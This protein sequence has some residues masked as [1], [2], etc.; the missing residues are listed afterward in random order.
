MANEIYHRSNWG[1]AVNDI[2]WGDVY[3]KFDATNEMFVRSDYYENS[4]ETDK[5]MADIYPKPSILLTPTAYDNGSLHS[6]KPVSFTS[7]EPTFYNQNG[8]SWDGSILLGSPATGNTS[9]VNDI[10]LDKK[11]FI[12]TFKVLTYV[13]GDLGYRFGGGAVN[14]NYFNSELIEGNTIKLE[15]QSDAT[16]NNFQFLTNSFNGSL[17]DITFKQLPAGDFDFTRGS[18]ATRV[19]EKG[20]IEDVQILSGNLVQN[21]DFEQ[22]GSELITNGTFDNNINGWSQYVSTSTW[23]NGTIKTTSTS[24]LAYIRQNNVFTQNK[25]YKVTFKAKATNITHNLKIYNG[26]SF[27]DTGLS[28]DVA[29]TY[30]EFTYYL[31]FVGSTINLIVGQSNINNGDSINFDNISVKEVGQNWTFWYRVELWEMVRL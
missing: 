21:G 14:F 29:D 31:N 22:I 28:F 27:I 18:S 15:V 5:L 20:L 1:N 23:D 11:N 30:K 25:Q 19:N 24:N 9:F 12:I 2:A 8:W 4:N 10:F 7:L 3:E 26:S 17:S 16:V 6:V 13:S